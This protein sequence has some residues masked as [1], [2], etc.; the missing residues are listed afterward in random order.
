MGRATETKGQGR[1][2]RA[3]LT[4][5]AGCML[6]FALLLLAAALSE[7]HS[8]IMTLKQPIAKCCLL[9]SAFVSGVIAGS[10]SREKRLLH[11]LC[12]EAV[13]FLFFACCVLGRRSEVRPLSIFVDTLFMLFGAFAGTFFRPRRKNKRGVK[14]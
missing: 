5:L 12:A 4:G 14:S 8:E 7:T 1:Y 6:F 3:A 9:I 2:L 13:L 11:A 10:G